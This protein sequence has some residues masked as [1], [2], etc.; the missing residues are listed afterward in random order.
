MTPSPSSEMEGASKMTCGVTLGIL[1]ALA[2]LCVFSDQAYAATEPNAQ[3]GDVF[4]KYILPS[5]VGAGSGF[6]GAWL[7]ATYRLREQEQTARRQAIA[8]KLKEKSIARLRYLDPLMIAATDLR[9]R[10]QTIVSDARARNE[11]W[12]HLLRHFTIVKDIPKY[13]AQDRAGLEYLCNGEGNR[14]FSTCMRRR[15]TSGEPP[16]YAPNCHS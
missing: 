14:A 3:A 6:G 1:A 13:R 10:L 2:V 8:E 15:S 4:L 12:Y 5:L 9:D 16:R 7:T 11:H